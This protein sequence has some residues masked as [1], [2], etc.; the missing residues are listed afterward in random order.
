MTSFRENRAVKCDYEG[1]KTKGCAQ[2]RILGLWPCRDA[3]PRSDPWAV[4]CF[5]IGVAL[6]FALLFWPN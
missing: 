5:L 3:G 6:L 4:V 2:E 1:C